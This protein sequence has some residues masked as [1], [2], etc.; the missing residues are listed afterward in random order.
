MITVIGQNG[1]YLHLGGPKETT[2]GELE[3]YALGITGYYYDI[4]PGGAACIP[5]SSDP[6]NY[7]IWTLEKRGLR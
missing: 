3:N 5:D 2:L 4:M 6:E 1:R 7:M